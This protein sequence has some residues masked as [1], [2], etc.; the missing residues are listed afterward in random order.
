MR[1]FHVGLAASGL[2][3]FLGV[4][5]VLAGQG[6]SVNEHSTCA[7]G[8]A[9]TAV[10]MPCADGSAMVFNPAGLASLAKG[11][12][13]F[14]VGAT[15]IA[16]SGGFTADATGTGPDLKKQVTP[17]PSVYLAHGFTDHIAAGIALFAPY[18]LTTE[19][20]DTSIVR[21]AAY[22]S[23][24]RNIYIQPTVAVGLGKYF[25]LGAGFDIN[26]DHLELR[27]RIDLASTPLPAPAPAGLTFANLG[28]PTGTD[29]ADAK[30]SGSKTGV[31][32]HLGAIIKPSDRISFGI[33][34][35]SRQKLDN[36]DGTAHITQVPT[37]IVLAAGNPFSQPGGPAIPA[38][39]PLDALLAGQF[40]GSGL[41][42]DQGGTTGVRLPEQLTVGVAVKPLN[43]LSVLFDLTY[44]NWTVF[45]ELILDFDRLPTVVLPEN[46]KKAYAYRFGAEYDLDNGTAIRAGFLTHN[47]AASYRTVNST[48]PEGDRSEFTAGFGSRLGSK[49]HF[50][51][52]YQY[53]DQADRRGRSGGPGSPNDGVYQFSAHLVGVTL[54]Y[55]F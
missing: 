18:G 48:L 28:I 52:A 49:L 16:P 6:Y 22:R 33:R 27:Q 32:Y 45:D 23:S 46:F 13:V 30:I 10:A 42:A 51:L 35:L 3:A 1:R 54:T 31:G 43:R 2:V 39:T 41:L 47:A 21:F 44:S 25:Q 24:I 4:P 14:S 40:T 37:N 12:T 7:M 8:R 11:Q 17:V 36:I 26:F 38:G 20:S 9:G 50:D 53:I 29:F 19:W 34:Y 5:S 55:K 15:F